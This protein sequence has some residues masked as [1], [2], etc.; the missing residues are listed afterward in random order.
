MEDAFPFRRMIFQVP[1]RS[2]LNVGVIWRLEV[3]LNC[4]WQWFLSWSV[5][6]NLPRRHDSPLTM[7]STIFW[8]NHQLFPRGRLWPLKKILPGRRSQFFM[9]FFWDQPPNKK[10]FWVNLADTKSSLASNYLCHFSDRLE[11]S[12]VEKNLHRCPGGR[13]WRGWWRYD[14]KGSC[15]SSAWDMG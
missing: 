14:Q 11:F 2:M 3:C 7:M 12:E 15:L 8:T 4:F 9:F 1:W 6:T 13:C 10:W 5:F